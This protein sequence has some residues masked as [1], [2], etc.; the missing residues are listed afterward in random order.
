MGVPQGVRRETRCGGQVQARDNA[1]SQTLHSPGDLPP[2]GA[3]G[4]G[5][6]AISTE[7]PG[8]IAEHLNCPSLNIGA[9]VFYCNG[10]L[11]IA[12]RRIVALRRSRVRSAMVAPHLLGKTQLRPICSD[13]R[14]SSRNRLAHRHA[15]SGLTQIMRA[16]RQLLWAK[17]RFITHFVTRRRR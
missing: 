11:G 17:S 2:T 12:V 8:N 16:Y 7:V 1:L 13:G 10:L 4:C 15:R 6:S 3:D 9:S 5:V 14:G